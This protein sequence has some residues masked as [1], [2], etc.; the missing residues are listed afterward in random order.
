[1]DYSQLAAYLLAKTEAKLEYPFAPDIPVFK[2]RGKM[3]ALVG[4]RDG[5][6]FINLK[7]QPE[8]ID[9]LTDIFPAIHRAYHMN[10]RHWLSLYFDGSDAEQQVFGLIDN[11]YGLVVANMSKSVQTLLLGE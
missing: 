4:W 9:A 1:M 3:F 11:S 8:Q 5:D 6:M 10:K 7:C 2:I